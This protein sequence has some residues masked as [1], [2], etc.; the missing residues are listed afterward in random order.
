MRGATAAPRVRR[1][2]RPAFSFVNDYPV[3]SLIAAAIV[4][5]WIVTR[6]LVFMHLHDRASDHIDFLHMRQSKVREPT[7]AP[8]VV[9][10]QRPAAAAVQA[11]SPP[12]PSAQ[13]QSQV[14]I[15]TPL[16]VEKDK[17]HPKK[18][19]LFGGAAGV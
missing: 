10:V 12:P 4:F 9:A 15:T 5:T 13:K 6:S 19:V 7:A 16:N 3:A 14:S 2:Y 17:C 18:N 1:E 11:S 8:S